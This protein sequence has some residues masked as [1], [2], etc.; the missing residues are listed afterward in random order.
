M[1]RP[2]FGDTIIYP[3]STLIVLMVYLRSAIHVHW[4]SSRAVTLVLLSGLLLLGMAPLVGTMSVPPSPSTSFPFDPLPAGYTVTFTE[5][6]LPAGTAWEVDF[7]GANQTSTS[8][9]IVFREPNG[10]HAYSIF[11]VPGWH[12]TSFPYYGNITVNGGP[13][14]PPTLIFTQVTYSV[15]FNETGLALGTNWSVLYNGTIHSSASTTILFSEPNGSYTFSVVRVPQYFAAPASGFQNVSGGPVVKPIR[16]NELLPSTYPVT[17]SE[18]G[19]PSGTAWGVGI[20]NQSLSSSSSSVSTNELN[21]SYQYTVTVPNGFNASPASGSFKVSGAPVFVLVNFTTPRPPPGVYVLTFSESGLPNGTVWQVSIASTTVS[22]AT[23]EV[24][25]SERNGTYPF[26]VGEEIGYNATPSVGN[27][28]VNGQPETIFVLFALYNPNGSNH[29]QNPTPPST[30]FGLPTDEAYVL[31]AALIILLLVAI[32]YAARS[33]SP[34]TGTESPRPPPPLA[35]SPPIET[36]ADP[37]TPSPPEPPAGHSTGVPVSIV[38]ASEVPV[39]EGDIPAASNCPVCHVPLN[40][41]GLCSI[42]GVQWSPRD[43]SE[44]RELHRPLLPSE[45]GSETQEPIEAPTHHEADSEWEQQM[46]ALQEQSIQSAPPPP[47]PPEKPVAAPFLLALRTG[48]PRKRKKKG[49]REA[50]AE[51]SGP[52]YVGFLPLSRHRTEEEEEEDPKP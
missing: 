1:V 23:S 46:G 39:P 40:D 35:A 9:S 49:S 19:L 24:Q 5:S 18:N 20:G 41:S 13:I 29:N 31:I 42:C 25:F 44:A 38:Q 4:R 10:T 2:P 27:A 43:L 12:E 52:S 50:P 32:A 16:F 14:S 33:G 21:G 17:F 36:S 28:T 34:E 47:P 11:G 51:G 37:P 6:G 45:T 7:N 22:S 26:T 48:K 3:F 30:L 8:T 15:S